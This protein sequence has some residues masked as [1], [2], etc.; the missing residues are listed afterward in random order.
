MIHNGAP[1]AGTTFYSI[2]KKRNGNHRGLVL[3]AEVEEVV[4]SYVTEEPM[5]RW[6]LGVVMA[7]H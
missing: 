1:L 7:V 3:V 6:R 4:S 2:I 5:K